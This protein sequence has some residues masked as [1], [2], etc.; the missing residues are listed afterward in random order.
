LEAAKRIGSVD[1]YVHT[2]VVIIVAYVSNV[3]VFFR[4][5]RRETYPLRTFEHNV[6]LNLHKS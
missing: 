4:K 1:V 6:R 2:R 3:G 5:M